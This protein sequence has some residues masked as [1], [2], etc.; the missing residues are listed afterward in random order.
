MQHQGTLA[1]RVMFSAS[2]G[3][4]ARS[5]T[6]STGSAGRRS[7]NASGPH[8]STRDGRR[9]ATTRSRWLKQLW[10]RSWPMLVAALPPTRRA[11]Q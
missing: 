4:V 3:N 2:S 6:S 7:R 8:G 10:Q 1:V 11:P 9:L 5:S